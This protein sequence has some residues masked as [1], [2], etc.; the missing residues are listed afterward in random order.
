MTSNGKNK[1]VMQRCPTPERSG[2]SLIIYSLFA[3]FPLFFTACKQERQPCLTPKTAILNVETM[4]IPSPGAAPVDTAGPHPVLLAV[5]A[6]G[7]QGGYYTQV[8]T[9]TLSLSPDADTCVWLYATDTAS[10]VLPDTITFRYQRNLQFLSNA[11]GYAYF[12]YLKTVQTTTHNIDSVRITDA[13]VTNNVN[14]KHLRIYI[15]P[16]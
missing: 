16:G 15:H 12:Y 7:E 14:T 2:T 5:T 3:F 11:C 6:T 8:A 1:S 10:A 9:F 4:H 13:N